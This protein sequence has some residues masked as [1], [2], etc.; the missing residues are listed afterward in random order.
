MKILFVSPYFKPYLGGIERVIE[1]LAL[2]FLQSGKVEKVGV[3]TTRWS[4]PRRYNQE[5]V[6]Y[7]V[8]DGIEVF[9][10]PSWPHT[11][12]PFSQVP[13][14]WFSPLKIKKVIEQFQ[15]D[16]ICLMSDKWI[17]G[18]FW[19]W[20][21][22]RLMQKKV[23][24]VYSLSFHKLTSKQQWLRPFNFF[25]TRIVDKVQVITNY[26]K[27]LVKKAYF[28]PE[29]KFVV[30]PWGVS[31]RQQDSKTAT[32][33][34][35]HATPKTVRLTGWPADKLTILCVGRLSKHK[36]Q[37]WLLQQYAEIV[38][39]LTKPT[40][41]VFVGSD[42]GL[43]STIQQFSNQAM[44]PNG[45]VIIAGEVSEDGLENWYQKAD[46]FALFPEY[47]AFGLV[48]LEAMAHGVPVLTHKV[49]AVEEVLDDAAMLTEAY[50]SAQVKVGLTKLIEDDKF[51][52]ELGQGGYNYVKEKFSWQKTAEKFLELFST[53]G[54]DK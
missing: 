39:N 47:E 38:G 33:P 15:P 27:E 16:V 6:D 18:N 1:K 53:H 48:F 42:E 31:A 49:G 23:R 14:V 25:L 17:W 45:E 30:I 40:K 20:V 10:I 44:K 37:A 5:W 8:I 52:Q 19:A 41:L 54:L 36:G 22:Q 35:K 11:A 13:L 43:L 7:E 12:P 29:S 2:Q 3:L 50:N 26:E 21:S 24:V 46:I 28:T 9:R 32:Q 34:K 51:R 4:F